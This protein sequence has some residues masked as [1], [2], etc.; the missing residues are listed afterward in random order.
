MQE[1]TIEQWVFESLP[2]AAILVGCRLVGLFIPAPFFRSGMLPWRLKIAVVAV[3][4]LGVVALL[5]QFGMLLVKLGIGDVS[6]NR[7]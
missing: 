7:Q 3:L 6:A 4:S 5:S 2:P 1:V